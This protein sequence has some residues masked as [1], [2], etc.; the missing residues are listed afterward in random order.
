MKDNILR[1]EVDFYQVDGSQ[2]VGG[3]PFNSV[4]FINFGTSVV[5]IE[6]VTLQ[7]SQQFEIPANANEVST[8]R[9]FVNFGTSTTGNDV[10]IVSK[11]YLNL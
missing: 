10:V 5:K 9:F 7:P 11:R 3:Q 8:Q 6:N 4:T 1:Y 2:Y